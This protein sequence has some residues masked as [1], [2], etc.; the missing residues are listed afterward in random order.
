MGSDEATIGLQGAE[1]ERQI[2][3]S[4]GQYPTGRAARQISLERVPLR[5]A[6]AVLFDRFD[7]GAGPPL[8]AEGALNMLGYRYLQTG[9]TA[10]A[11][12]ALRMGAAWYPRS[13]NAWDSY[14]EA[15]AAHGDRETARR[16]YLKVQ[17][18]LPHD[19]ALSD[20]LRT[21]LTE[22]AAEALRQLDADQE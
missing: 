20:E 22:R 21:Q 18:L 17:E 10:G 14:G 6:A 7:L 2:R 9:R 12:A 19:A 15:A 1:I 16:C 3:H 5:H 13:T 4:G 8:L 11:V